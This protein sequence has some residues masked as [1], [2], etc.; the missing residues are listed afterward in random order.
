MADRGTYVDIFFRNGLKE[1][2]VLPPPDVWDSIQPILRKK[3]RSLN[4]L[5]FAAIA[6]IPISISVFSFW[7]T[8]EISKNFNEPSISLNQDAIPSGSYVFKS[9]PVKTPVIEI[10][11]IYAETTRPILVIETNNSEQQ[12]LKIPSSG[13]LSLVLKESKL[14]K[15]NGPVIAKSKLAV[16]SNSAVNKYLGL[17]PGNSISANI[18]NVINRWTISA[19]ASPTYF[20]SSS[21]GKADA[22]TDLAKNEKPAVS[23]A[24]GMAF[25]Y[26]VNKRISV[27]SGIYYSSIGQKIAGISAY[28]GFRSYYNAKGS[29][30][31]S[32]QTSSGTI[33]STNNDIFLRDNISGRVITRYTSDAFDPAKAGLT[34][35]DNSVIQNFNYLEVPVFF[36]FKAIDSK[37]DLNLI[38]GLSYNMLVGNS[39]F[40]Y[41][42]GVK[43]S[44]GK[45]DG[46]SPVNFSSSF[47]LGFE[48][49]F[50]GKISLNLE[51]TFRYYLTPLGG[52]VGS[53]SHPYSFGVFSGLSYKF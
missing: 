30:E 15:D 9:H 6:A 3:Q 25:S 29:S 45:T 48:Y 8:T 10:P 50:S 32:I 19:L 43:Y 40:T 51:P 13:L 2:E 21:F 35:L 12:N 49:N 42:S 39:A 1:F 37:I 16:N 7:L 23:Y 31:F 17:I 26:K 5:R 18:G 33:V 46:L 24:G 28:S 44:I 11:V 14:R 22:S 47:G 34:Y 27:W 38:G 20:S 36:K 52:L 4:I 53:S 41:V